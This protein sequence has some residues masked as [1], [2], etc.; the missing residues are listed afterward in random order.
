MYTTQQSQPNISVIMTAFN[1]ERYIGRAIE[2]ILA[3]T[4][5][6]FEFIIC[7]D[8]STDRT[9]AIIQSYAKRDSRIKV[10]NN[11]QN[12]G[13]GASANRLMQ[14]AQYDLIVRMDADDIALPYRLDLQVRYMLLHPDVA[15]L[16]GQCITIDANDVLVGQ[17]LFPTAEERIYTGLFAFMTIQQPST[18]VNRALFPK[19][20]R[21]F[22]ED[23]SPVDDLDFI[24]RAFAYGRVVNLPEFLIKYRVYASSASMRDPKRTF[25]L[26]K[27]VRSLAVAEYGYRPS[28]M[29]RIQHN[30]Q[31]AI[32]PLLP[33]SVIRSIYKLKQRAL[34]TPVIN[35][36]DYIET[37][38]EGNIVTLVPK[39]T[40]LVTTSNA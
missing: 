39:K 15:V 37:N 30:L 11:E 31:A 18:I 12:K 21:F 4:Y 23:I 24:F 14:A 10:L 35:P 13:V 38:T 19:D 22:R 28:L 2:S 27:F 26:T 34:Y 1:A 20:Y 32:V 5:R 25:L 6:D 3:Q 9:L 40:K 29:K 7:D 8:A 16:G 36:V 33:N 17:K